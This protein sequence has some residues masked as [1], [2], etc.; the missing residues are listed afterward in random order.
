MP[1][2]MTRLSI[3]LILCLLVPAMAQAKTVTANVILLDHVLV[4]NRLGSQNVNGMIYA[5]E[6]DVVDSNLVPLSKGGSRTPGQVLLRPDKRPRPLVLRVSVGDTLVINFE[7]LLTQ[8]SNPDP[9]LPDEA[10]PCDP[11]QG[12]NCGMN[13]PLEVLDNQVATRWGGFHV[14]GMELATSISDDSS[15]VGANTNSLATHSG[16]T[17]TYNYLAQA[18]GTFLVTSYGATFGGEATGGNVGIGAFAVVNVQPAGASYYRSQVTE[19]ELRLASTGVTPD[20]HPILPFGVPGVGY[21][22]TYPNVQPWI[23]EGKAGL[24]ILNM[25]DSGNNI[26]HADI[27]AIV[28]GSND[29]GSFPPGTYPL[30]ADGKRN[31]TVPNRLEPFREFTIVFHDETAAANA[32]PGWFDPN[33]DPV[34]AHTTHSVRDSFM[35]NYGSG[36]IGSEIIANRL[37]V[38]PMWDCLDCAYEEFFLTAF[39]VGDPAMLVDVPA[40]TGLESCTAKPNDSNCTVVGPKATKAF[41]P[42]DPSNVHHSY[43]GDF[44]KFRNL[45]AGPKEQHIFHLHNH[46]WLFNANDDNSNYIDAQGIGPGSGYTY[47]INFGG[48]GNRNKT[49][50]DAIFHCH[51]YPHFAQGMW[52]MWRVHDTTEVGTELAVSYGDIHHDAFALKDGTPAAKARALPDGEILDGTPIPAVVPLPGK[53]MAPMPGR[54]TV[55]AKDA[56]ADGWLDSSQA[57]V[58]RADVYTSGPLAGQLK[59]PG[60]PFWIAGVDC[61]GPGKVNPLTGQCD[62]GIVGQR[63]TTPPLDMLTK[64][65][66]QVLAEIGDPLFSHPGLEASAGGFD[67]GLPRHALDGCLATES[68]DSNGNPIPC[69]TDPGILHQVQTRFDFSKEVHKAKPI[70][71]PEQGTDLEQAA[72]RFHAELNLPSYLAGT[73]L[74]ITALYRTNGNLPVAGAPFAEPCVDDQGDLFTT[75]GQF[76]GA[77]EGSF[78]TATAPQAKATAP[79]VYKAANIQIDAIFNKVGYHFPQQRIISLWEDV[80]DFDRKV[81]P[82]EPFVIRMNTF[83]CTQ[84]YHSNLVPKD[85]QL[86]DYQVRTPTDIIGQHIHLPKWDLVAAD[87]SANGWNYEDGTLAPK[88]VEERIRAINKY[89][90]DPNFPPVPTLPKPDGS[91]GG[92]TQLSRALNPDPSFPAAHAEALGARTTIQR[93]FA[94]PVINTDLEDRGLGIIF[95]HDH[96][97]PSTHQQVGLY[98]TVLTEPAGSTWLHNETGVQLATRPDGGPTTWQAVITDFPAGGVGQPADNQPFREFYFEFADFQHAYEKEAEGVLSQPGVEITNPDPNAFRYAIN[99]PVREELSDGNVFPD[100][101]HFPRTCPGGVPRP[102]PEAISADDVGMLVVN[103]RNEP[104]GLRVFDPAANGPDNKPGSQAAGKAG[105]LAFALQTRT[106]RAISEMNM[107]PSDLGF[108]GQTLNQPNAV[109]H[110]DPFTPMMRT[111]FGD[112]IKVK[113]QA[114]AHEHE[115]NATLH[116]LKWL[117]GGSGHG[118][119]PNSGWRGSQNAGIS[120]Q[121]TLSTPIFEDVS[122]R[123]Q[124]MDLAYAMDA[125]QDGWWSGAWG[126]IR[127]YNEDRTDLVRLQNDYVLEDAINVTNRGAFAGFCPLDDQAAKSYDITAVLANEVL[128]NALGATIVPSDPSA[129]MHVG[130]PLDANGG[131]LVYN[132]RGGAGQSRRAQFDGPLHDPTGIMYVHTKDL[133]PQNPL[134]PRCVL[135]SKGVVPYNCPAQLKAGVP[136]EPLVLRAAA[137]DCVDV[138]L[139]N[140]LPDEVPD[141]AGYNTLMQMVIRDHNDS[142]GGVTTFNNNLIRPSSYVGIHPQMV[143]FDSSRDNGILVGTNPEAGQLVAPGGSKT[144]RWF[145]GHFEA[146][147]TSVTAAPVEFGGSNLQP[148]DVIKQGQKGLVGALVVEP[149]N[150]TWTTDAG[151]RAAATI[152]PNSLNSFR[153]FAVVFQKGL[154]LRHGDARPVPNIPGEGSAV[155]EDSHDAG[156]AAINY[157]TEPAWYRF[158]L[159]ASSPFGT[160][161]GEL[162]AVTGAHRLYANGLAGGYPETPVFTAL[163]SRPF[164]MRVLEPTGVGRGTTFNL[165]GHVW[166]RDPYLEGTVPSQTIGNNPLGFYL[167]GQESVTPAAH[168]D[169]VLP[170]AGGKN[171]ILGDYLFRDHG[172]F[173]NTNGLWGILK[174]STSL[175]PADPEVPYEEVPREQSPGSQIP[176]TP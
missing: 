120:E 102:C 82:P 159:P 164:R 101:F 1:H 165:H 2:P 107:R 161:T 169:V 94:D 5:L 132:A 76:F 106:D 72:M 152:N 135:G 81:R 88:M 117:Q 100:I 138:T 109:E 13:N 36:G 167:G 7:N 153:D 91:G 44:V 121:F 147:G 149:E 133:E 166:Q 125:S 57:D 96:F 160:G 63:P 118:E 156:Q 151:S 155:P 79:R 80:L 86:D 73:S 29:D 143:E 60:F 15:W 93:W 122:T 3:L 77:T 139:R 119:A 127:A 162:G 69:R 47:E 9:P 174:V 27:N 75:T 170:S 103:Y 64:K 99:P 55:V 40:N 78:F 32:F 108:W 4:F 30:E 148:A 48:S 59:N 11:G 52:E 12:S 65:D 173:G 112:L 38:G 98:A 10:N 62:D 168:F 136:I 25:L 18:E 42:D 124:R 66:A 104:V 17:R 175:P 85:Y 142:D 146:N 35:I 8:N 31:P 97:G 33:V 6:R 129:T 113:I 24:P 128:G 19:E 39:A 105:D 150:A 92:L 67:G 134:D 61:G 22:K 115:H 130:G 84:Y 116:G 158:R 50:G 172:S 21:E 157:G 68:L 111:R 53:A 20:G 141:L 70:Y 140:R 89:N 49:A 56:N 83:E 34:I 123:N 176:L 16:G 51:F 144:F 58:D 37:G 163:R 45:H 74:P 95:T 54:V 26:V 154:N 14:Q 110:G 137:G 71:Y 23:A 126:V 43:T 131:T 145:M 46:Q 171:G 114:G 41:Y 90:A 28:V 87:G